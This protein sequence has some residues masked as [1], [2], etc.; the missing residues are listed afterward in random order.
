MVGIEQ[1]AAWS[2]LQDTSRAA[3]VRVLRSLSPNLKGIYPKWSAA[4][5][6][7]FE[8]VTRIRLE[9]QV[10]E[11]EAGRE[12]TNRIAPSDLA[13]LARGQL[14]SA[15]REVADAQHALARFVPLGM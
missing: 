8:L 9:H 14:R 6:E 12:P 1:A 3:E 13:P 5:E 15:L 7:G 10:A 11:V 4:L 2:R